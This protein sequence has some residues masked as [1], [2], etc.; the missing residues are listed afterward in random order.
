MLQVVQTN[1]NW[2]KGE[3]S[4]TMKVNIVME[5]ICKIEQRNKSQNTRR[6]VRL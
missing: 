5:I 3:S 4:M 2:L 6:E 1:A